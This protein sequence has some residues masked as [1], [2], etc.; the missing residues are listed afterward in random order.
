MIVIHNDFG[1][2]RI[3]EDFRY[4]AE[5]PDGRY[6][7]P[8]LSLLR[9]YPGAKV[10][11]AHMGM[12][13]FTEPTPA[14]V[15]MWGR[16][17]SDPGLRHVSTD[18]SWNEVARHLRSTQEIAD[19]FVDLAR[20]HHDRLVYGTDSV[21]PE[22]L[23]QYFRQIHD[24]DP[25]L[26]RVRDEVSVEAWSNI[27]HANLERL[28]IAARRD[29][30]QWAYVHLRSGLWDEV[31]AQVSPE[32]RRM[33]DAWMVRYRL[34]RDESTLTRRDSDV[35]LVGPGRWQDPSD[36]AT[37]QLRN[38]LR[39][40]NAVTS[41]VVSAARLITWKLFVASLQAS[42]EDHQRARAQ[43]AA[44]TGQGPALD[45]AHDTSGLGLVDPAGAP[46]TVDALVA[47]DQTRRA[48]DDPATTRGVLAEVQRTQL[49]QDA[50][51]REM[52]RQRHSFLVKAAIGAAVV[53]VVLAVGLPLMQVTATLSYAM[54]AVRGA[55]T[56]YR[57]AYS[58]QIR[59]MIESI[60]ERGQFDPNT[61]DV[62]IAKTRK[63]A[64]LSGAGP[65]RMK[66][67]DKTTD[68]FRAEVARIAEAWDTAT[69][70]GS[71]SAADIQ[72]LRDRALTAFS[73]MLDR[74][75]VYSGTQY[76]SY[77][78]ISADAG[79]LGRV[80]NLVLAASYAV[81]FD[82]HLQQAG[83]TS[84]LELW[85]NAVYA[86]TDVL[87]FLP[88]IASVVTGFAGKDVAGHHPLARKLVHLLGLPI[89][90]LA[91]ALLTVQMAV[92]LNLLFVVPAA[93]LTIATAYLTKLG[94]AVELGLGRIAPRKGAY[95]NAA[96]A[97]GL[98]GFG[99][100]GMLPTAWPALAIGVVGGAAVLLGLSKI[101]T[102]LSNRAR[103]PPPALTRPLRDATAA[104]LD[105]IRDEAIVH[106][107]GRRRGA[108]APG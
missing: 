44:A 99:V 85:V 48:F 108:G 33:L 47:A 11:F 59:V 89:I 49:G 52:A 100:I 103:A 5:R 6:G 92:E 91:N 57:T 22:S 16:I 36:E 84:G 39:W 58:Q 24:L 74:V 63:Y 30:Q 71:A 53:A 106:P 66:R 61:I 72:V 104:D 70:S 35:P 37:G 93:V 3:L 14:Y 9:Q 17:L 83:A 81:H 26:D 15:R 64:V 75:G 18:I 86:V 38:L 77:P 20:H 46:Y 1:L 76:Q 101:D 34:E 68:E 80:V 8:L 54:F 96:L 97:A 65:A 7:M 73:E 29:V 88:A 56:L 25:L 13:K 4:G 78:S 19:A 94:L 55:L 12:G 2:A 31:L 62:L 43:R 105:R 98:L 41:E 60:L 42:V 102:W 67:L 82:W 45:G 27:R 107:D 51:D 95:A 90:T 79:L 87:F 21:K 40:H 10:I 50:A 69:R 23:A 32:H 28:L